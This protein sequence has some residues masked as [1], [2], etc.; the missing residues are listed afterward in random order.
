MKF[1]PTTLDEQITYHRVMLGEAKKRLA[2]AKRAVYRAKDQVRHHQ[3][4]LRRI[5]QPTLFGDDDQ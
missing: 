3:A 4:A 2:A 1:R 5:T